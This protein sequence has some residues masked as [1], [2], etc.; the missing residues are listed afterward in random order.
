MPIVGRNKIMWSR[1]R[2]QII[3]RVHE[4]FR[5]SFCMPFY[6]SLL[7]KYYLK[8]KY[9][10]RPILFPDIDIS[11]LNMLGRYNTYL[12]LTYIFITTN[13]KIILVTLYDQL[14]ISLNYFV[15]IKIFLVWR[16][17]KRAIVLLAHD[18]SMQI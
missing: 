7:N 3:S 11:D 1:H 9:F 2:F 10:M 18:N 13:P 12:S 6:C 15:Y 17:W 8:S 16:W 14:S 5:R 4:L